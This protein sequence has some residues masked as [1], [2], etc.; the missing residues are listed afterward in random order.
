M[1][2]SSFL[3]SSS[4]EPAR[5]RHGGGLPMNAGNDSKERPD[6]PRRFLYSTSNEYRESSGGPGDAGESA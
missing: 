6:A 5:P 1:V 3:F 4:I 2:F